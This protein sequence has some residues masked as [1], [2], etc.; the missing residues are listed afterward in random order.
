MFNISVVK[1][2]LKC[3]GHYAAVNLC[4]SAPGSK[5]HTPEIKSNNMNYLVIM[6]LTKLLLVYIIIFSEFIYM[7]MFTHH[8]ELRH[9]SPLHNYM[10]CR[11]LRLAL[12]IW[13]TNKWCSESTLTMLTEANS[14]LRCSNHVCVKP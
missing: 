9:W 12:H 11:L 4:F 5:D 8:D 14:Q 6:K 10:E 1:L 3:D 7:I 2:N 13:Q